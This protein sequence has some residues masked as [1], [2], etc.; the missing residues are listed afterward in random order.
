MSPDAPR[1]AL[2]AE[3]RGMPAD[4]ER[5][6]AEL[7]PEPRRCIVC[8]GAS[9]ARLFHRSGKWF[10]RCEGCTLVFVHDIYPEFAVD[11][12][13]L[14]G[15]YVLDRMEVAGPRKL[16]KYDALLATLA[17]WRRTGRLLEVG[18]GQG[19]FL[20][21]AQER[22]WD[23]QGVEIL[24]PVAERAR[25]RGLAVYLGTL[26]EAGLPADAFDAVVMREVIEHVVDPVALLRET[27][28][29]LRPSGV[30]ALETGNARSWSARLRG[31]GW[32]YYRF[33]GHLHI[34]FWSPSSGAA[35]ARAAGFARADAATSGFA[36]REAE[37]MRGRW[38]KPLAKLAQGP[39]STLARA[40]GA[41]HRL[42]LL[43]E[44]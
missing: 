28:R 16:A 36:F 6:I 37:E 17:P 23:V 12:A 44:K 9:F 31:A 32:A 33:G 8:A 29:V 2:P 19:L 11:T 34:R 27:R 18:C 5:A 15:T 21:R 13:H 10:W 4:L 3:T 22:G 30:A 14:D 43:L 41:G 20:A 26:E 25:E 7:G 24:A 1:G 42:T 35:L 38:Y 40:A 39:L